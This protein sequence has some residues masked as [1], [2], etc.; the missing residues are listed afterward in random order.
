MPGL[1]DRVQ[2]L[3][4]SVSAFLIVLGTAAATIPDFA[5]AELKYQF[6]LVFWFCGIIGLGLKEAVGSAYADEQP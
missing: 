6:A 4:L 5:P 2:A 1:T 3:F